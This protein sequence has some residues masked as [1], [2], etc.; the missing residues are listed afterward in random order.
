MS[1]PTLSVMCTEWGS[2]T[3]SFFL[4]AHNRYAWSKDDSEP[5]SAYP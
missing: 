3:T 2:I 4:A 5:D 1:V